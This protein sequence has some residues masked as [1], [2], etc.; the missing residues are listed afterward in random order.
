M[1][2]L[3]DRRTALEVKIAAKPGADSI[4]IHPKLALVLKERVAVLI[5]QL[6]EPDGMLE[7]KE[8]LRALIDRIV[9]T[10]SPTI[11]KL[12]IDIKDAVA[13]PLTLDMGSKRRKG[14]T[15]V[16]QAF[17]SVRELALR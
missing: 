12:D 16:G 2:A 15:S 14:M 6:I 8:A 7:A 4:R 9:L 3:D 1:Q 17:E 5:S 11:G 10:P 13:G